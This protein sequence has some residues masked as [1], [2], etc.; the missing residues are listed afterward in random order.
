M[1]FLGLGNFGTG[2]VTGFAQSVDKAV[3]DDIKRVNSRI[4]K[5]S[6]IRVKRYLKK[7]DEREE[8]VEKD[9]TA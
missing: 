4:D 6:D 5:I 1:G 2:F 8:E 9:R 7:K 3:Q